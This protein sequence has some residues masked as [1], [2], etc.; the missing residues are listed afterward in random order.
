MAD[1]A[2]RAGLSTVQ[3]LVRGTGRLA[4]LPFIAPMPAEV[5]EVSQYRIVAVTRFDRVRNRGMKAGRP[6]QVHEPGRR[7]LHRPATELAIFPGQVRIADAGGVHTG[8]GPLQLAPTG[9]AVD[10]VATQVG[11]TA[12]MASCGNGHGLAPDEKRQGRRRLF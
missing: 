1:Q 5:P 12:G 7:S 8:V 2:W 9:I 3:L 10:I 6:Q 4:P 11:V